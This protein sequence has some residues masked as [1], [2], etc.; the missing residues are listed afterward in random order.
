MRRFVP[1]ITEPQARKLACGPLPGRELTTLRTSTSCQTTPEKP[2]RHCSNGATSTTM[3]GFHPS[4]DIGFVPL[5]Y[6]LQKLS[7]FRSNLKPRVA[8]RNG[9][10]GTESEVRSVLFVS[11]TQPMRNT[12]QG[13][14]VALSD[15]GLYSPD[16]GSRF[17]HLVLV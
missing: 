10:C 12:W 11:T 2:R 14:F 6:R 9:G 4:I 7:P 15:E 8:R 16:P 13:S 1:Q 17:E 3:A 5:P